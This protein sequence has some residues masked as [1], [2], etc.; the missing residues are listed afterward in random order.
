MMTGINNV[1]TGWHDLVRRLEQRLLEI[2]PDY[3]LLQIKEKFGGLRYY[4]NS[5]TTTGDILADPF[6]MAISEA[7]AESDQTCERCGATEGVEQ[8]ATFN[9]IKTLCP[10]HRAEDEERHARAMRGAEY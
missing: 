8:R 1:G 2:D 4:A 10:T 6:H 7:E 5:G 3:E 9:W